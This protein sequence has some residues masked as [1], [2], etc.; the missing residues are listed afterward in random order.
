MFDDIG[1]RIAKVL[2]KVQAD[3]SIEIGLETSLFVPGVLDS[4]GMIEF[5]TALEGEFNIKI[6]NEDLIPEN[7]R[8]IKVTAQLIKEYLAGKKVSG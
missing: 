6:S 4:F 2:N 8:T 7:F 5:L 3:K 1:N